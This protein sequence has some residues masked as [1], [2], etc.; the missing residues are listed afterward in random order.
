MTNQDLLSEAIKL[1]AG[2]R[3]RFIRRLIESLDAQDDESPEEVELLWA[4][5]LE[6][7]ASRA[8]AGE[9][10]AGSLDQV[11]GELLNRYRR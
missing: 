7:R 3:G 5:E 9:P 10:A 6:E 8:L 1:P 2:E 11:C 4:A